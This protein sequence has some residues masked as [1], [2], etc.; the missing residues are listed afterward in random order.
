MCD[1]PLCFVWIAW[2][3]LPY[4]YALVAAGD[5]SGNERRAM[6]GPLLRL[7][8][9]E[10]YVRCDRKSAGSRRSRLIDDDSNIRNE[11]HMITQRGE[12]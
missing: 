12:K 6:D 3:V 8:A 9:V 11:R 2:G 7:S 4:S 5:T 10:K 1:I